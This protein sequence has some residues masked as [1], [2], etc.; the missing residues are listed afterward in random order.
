VDTPQAQRPPDVTLVSHVDR[1]ADTGPANEHET[2]LCREASRTDWAYLGGLIVADSAA[3]ALDAAELQSNGHTAVR[4][5]GPGLVG[6]AWGWSV[7]GTYLTL[8]QCGADLVRGHA[9]EGDSRSEIPLAVSFGILAATTAPVIVGIETGDGP[10]TLRWSPA[11]RVM[12]LVLASATATVGSVL[13]YVLP[14]RTWR[15]AHKLA[16]LR[17]GAAARG[18]I[19]SYSVTF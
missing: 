9:V 12:R 17:V 3:V 4:L 2:G 5:V 6:L 19:V 7:G 8:P 14:P 11:E 15:A 10:Q 18:G 13:P 16:N 1:P